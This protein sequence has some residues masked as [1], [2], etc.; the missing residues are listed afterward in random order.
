[1][2]GGKPRPRNDSV[3]FGDDGGRDVD[4]GGDDHRAQR[5]GQDV[6]H[7]EAALAGAERARRLD[8]LLLAQGQELGA[9]QPRHRHPAQAADDDDDEDE[10]AALRPEDGLE[11]VAEEIDH[12]QQQ[13]QRRQRQE[14]VGEPHQARADTAARHA[15][16][17]ADDGAD[18]DG[19]HHGGQADGERDAP[20]IEHA[21][22]QVLAEIV[23]A[24]A[25]A[26]TTA[27]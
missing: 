16:D 27:P 12:Q 14:Q 18:H 9:H 13:R 11:G 20:A 1:M 21:R 26:P 2:S 10:D 3:E 19:D 4:R 22:Q 24:Q 6:A 15:G 8:E 5:V 25:D 7:D 17:G 23:G